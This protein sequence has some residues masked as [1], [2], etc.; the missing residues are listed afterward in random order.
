MPDFSYIKCI[1]KDGAMH[2][3]VRNLNTRE[4]FY[5]IVEYASQ[6]KVNLIIS[7]P[8][9]EDT[10]LGVENFTDSLWIDGRCVTVQLLYHLQQPHEIFM[11]ILFHQEY[12]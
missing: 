2:F 3:L 12:I 7:S 4:K 6:R 1:L 5:V 10:Y 9:P 11:R 8:L